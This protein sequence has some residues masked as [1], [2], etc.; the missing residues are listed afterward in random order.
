MQVF[1]VSAYENPLKTLILAKHAHG[2]LASRALGTIMA[3]H[4]SLTSMNFD[5]IVPVPLHVRRE[6]ERGYNQA[7]ILAEQI[8]LACGKP[9]VPCLLRTKNTQYQSR[10]TVAEKLAN[11]EDAFIFQGHDIEDRSLLLVD[12]LMTSGA[13]LQAAARTLLKHNPKKIHGL[14]G[15]LSI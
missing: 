15:C 13:T 10:L 12:D 2:Y 11:V 1:A 14:V 3:R 5:F 4:C 9:V 6:R 8:S 7:Y